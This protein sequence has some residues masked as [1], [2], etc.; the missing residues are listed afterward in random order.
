MADEVR[1]SSQGPDGNGVQVDLREKKFMLTGPNV[2]LLLLI[3]IIGAVAWLRTGK[4]D[5]TLKTG[6]EQLTATEGRVQQRVSELFGRM[7]KL[8]DDLQRQND[9]LNANN[10]KVTT[11]QHELR[12]HLDEALVRQDAL[13]H[14]QTEAVEA[15]VKGLT[16][17]VEAWFSELGKR[18]E[19]LNHNIAHPDRALPLRSPLP[20]SEHGR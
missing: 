3:C 18:F 16:Q 6:Q 1:V 17:Y 19:I 10:A 4:I 12:T 11:G 2:A 5:T 9:L 8:L 13:V 7:D 14:T 15:L 20:P